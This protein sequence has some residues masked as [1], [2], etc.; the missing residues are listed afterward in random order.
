MATETRSDTPEISLL[1]RLIGSTR[2]LLRSA[3]TL[4][5]MGVTL[6]VGLILLAVVSLTDLAVPLRP[7]LRMV[8]L[9]L[10][11]V[12]SIW[13][14]VTGVLRP[15]FRRMT[16]RFVARRIESTLPGIHNRL[17]SC[18]DLDLQKQQQHSPAFLKRLL[19]EAVER[20][21]N[22]RPW[23]VVDQSALRRAGLF[24]LGGLIVFGTA[25][26]L[27]SDRLPTALARI[28]SPFADIPPATGVLF[29]VQPGTC[30]VL[31]GEPVEFVALITKGK[32]DRLRLEL[33]EIEGETAGKTL[34]H[35][36]KPDETGR[37]T[38]RLPSYEHSFQYRVHGGGTWTKL[39]TVTMLERPRL[40]GLQ[41]AVHYPDYMKVSEP[42]VNPPD[43]PEV[44]GPVGS[45]VELTVN[46]EGDASVGEVQLLREENKTV[47]VTDRPQRVWFENV[48]PKGHAVEG[49]W[50]W[51]P[52]P[53]ELDPA[54]EAAKRGEN[55][56]QWAKWHTHAAAPGLTYHSFH[57]AAVPFEI[58]VGDVLFAEVFVEVN[59]LP[60]ELMLQFHDGVNWEHRAFWGA[61]K[62]A[63]GQVDSNSR[64]RLG[65]I[66]KAGEWARLE[67]PARALD[68]EGRSIRG[69]S[70]TQF[71]GH[72][73]WGKVG[74]IPPAT[75]EVRE[76]V[77]AEA[78]P[79]SLVGPAV[80]DAAKVSVAQNS[81][82]Q[83]TNGK[84]RS[85]YAAIHEAHRWSGRFPIKADGW[86]RIEL[87]NEIGAAN[88]QMKEAR[89]VAVPDNPP[90]ILIERPGV[91][92]V[93][94]EPVKVPLVIAAFD[95]FGLAELVLSTQ[96][97]ENTGFQGRAVKS[98]SS[99]TR[100]DTAIVML[101]LL[102]ESLKSGDVFKYRAEVRDRK[103]QTAQTQDFTIRIVAN[104]PNAAD[105]KL[106]Q[107]EK[108]ED[109]FKEKLVELITKQKA[110]QEKLEKLEEKYEPL[111]EKVEAAQAEAEKAAEAA[112]KE[113]AAKDQAKNDPAKPD[114]S[115]PMPPVTP[116][117]PPETKLDAEAQKMLNEL[118]QELAQL[119]QQ[120]QQN[121]AAAE[122]L[123]EQLKALAAEADKQQLVPPQLQREMQNLSE[124]FQEAA[125]SPLKELAAEIQK[126]AQP[127]Q[128]DPK[129]PQLEARGEQALQNLEAIKERMEALQEAQKDSKT[130]AAKALEELQRE[131]T[132]QSGELSARE[133]AEL[134][135]A[136]EALR[137][138]LQNLANN[139]AQLA[140]FTPEAPEVLVP[141]LEKKQ[142][143]LDLKAEKELAKTKELQKTDEYKKLKNK[144]QPQF[145]DRPYDPDSR[146][147]LTPPNEED[148]PADEAEM[149][150]SD[151]DNADA[152][153]PDA[154]NADANADE[155]LFT[156]ALG[157][158]KQKED[159]RFKDKKRPTPKKPLKDDK[160]KPK[161]KP[162]ANDKAQS[163][164]PASEAQERRSELSDR[165]EE[166]LDQLN[167]AEESLAADQ[168]ALDSLLGQLEKALQQARSKQLP[169]AK[170]QEASQQP[171]D[172]P[173]A[174][175][176][177]DMA[178]ANEAPELSPQAAAELAELLSSELAQ[179][180][181]KMAARMQAMKAGDASDKPNKG[182]K[183]PPSNQ[184]PPLKSSPRPRSGL[185][186]DNASQFAME[187][188]LK[189]LD[190]SSKAIILKMQ[191]RMREEL[192]QGLRE[193]GPEGY[194]RFIRDYF[195]RLTKAGQG[196]R[197]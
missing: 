188:I 55:L 47:A 158:P 41:A 139:Q 186:G 109:T 118:K 18:V 177:P 174:D 145:P 185:E 35:D 1:H 40:V 90:Q 58:Q 38:F 36:L 82:P 165:Q 72:C 123:K 16:A 192:L 91:D 11:V 85:H 56:A 15:L 30:K 100:A 155:E 152:N 33:V 74:T 48:L 77:V 125:V 64:R 132:R 46:V 140:E 156:P 50:E 148:T 190:P 83:A 29:D 9:L 169:N 159:P 114:V 97:G 12:P 68:L 101:D 52:Q 107:F 60:E 105:K 5:G 28:F 98:Y 161:D 129:L 131:M 37:W 119:Q 54:A 79:L 19:T 144:R 78:F 196:T 170:S 164:D 151:V 124:A 104:D 166:R 86:Y 65:D 128:N 136:I 43:V 167:K 87:K 3:W 122:Q 7:W 142:D 171:M 20:V 2:S 116:P 187:A 179:K 84:T 154:D 51:H 31:R 63:V 111:T 149:A 193:E 181:M 195:E 92:L 150:K 75:R 147:E 66:P 80:E 61:D 194:Q 180:A 99:L 127:K 57:S 117:T 172:T 133:L 115:K 88:Q 163:N 34:W 108:Q 89:I 141:D 10:V 120:E 126:S 95:D 103:G 138:E 176:D 81:K 94:S 121:A 184:P 162:Q 17:V 42:R 106:A 70:F 157:S 197:K 143:D 191:P 4:T 102:Q 21:K 110:V 24:A 44:S 14:F 178:D 112:A 13:A 53:K 71:S 62:I 183:Q 23:S 22:F 130:D 45:T 59:Q 25:F 173:P 146:E 113:Q 189:D 39:A 76:L 69:V 137:Q 168:R 96:K 175:G 160:S 73:L 93:L 32:V 6:G 153:K 182:Q 135:A 8:A 67:I 27:F 49:R 26:G 134:R